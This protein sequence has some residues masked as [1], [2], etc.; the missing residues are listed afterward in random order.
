MIALK[1][2]RLDSTQLN[3]TQLNS[4]QL[5]S[6]QLN[7]TQLNTTQLNSTQLNS[8][9]INSTQLNSTQ[10][11]SNQLKSTQINLILLSTFAS[12]TCLCD[13]I[14]DIGCK[15]PETQDSYGHIYDDLTAQ[16]RAVNRKPYSSVG[17]GSYVRSGVYGFRSY[18]P[19]IQPT[20]YGT[21]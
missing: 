7:S 13:Q 17:S 14:I 6:T 4:T 5:N 3:S 16:A 19:S 2:T 18:L 10:I 15:M 20:A 1:Q 9:L 11:N 21:V 8:T 12:C